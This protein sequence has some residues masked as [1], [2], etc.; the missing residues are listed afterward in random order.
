MGKY[1]STKLVILTIFLACSSVFAKLD[2]DQLNKAIDKEGLNWKAGENWVTRL[3]PEERKNLVGPPINYNRLSK[4]AQDKMIQLPKTAELPEHF[5]WRKNNGNWVTPVK[6]QGSCGSCWS[7]SAVAQTESWWV[8]DND[9]QDTVE[10]FDLSEQYLLAEGSA[11]GCDGG[12]VTAALDVARETGI[13]PEWCLEY[14]MSDTVEIEEADPDWQEYAYQIPGW[15][16]VTSSEA[17][18]KNIKNALLYHPVSASYDVYESFYYYNGGVYEPFTGEHISLENDTLVGGH[19]ILLVG[20]DDRDSSWICKNSWGKY[21]PDSVDFDNDGKLDSGYF[22]I[23]WG[24]C[25]I[26]E[27][28]P[29]IWNDQTQQGNIAFEQNSINTTAKQ[30][31]S[32]QVDFTVTNTGAETVHFAATD[33]G[34]YFHPDTF[35]AYEGASWWCGDPAIMGYDNRVLQYLYIAGLNLT[36][37]TEPV[38]EFK[39][40]WSIEDPAGA[41]EWGYDGWDGW[42]VW[43]STDG[44]NDRQVIEPTSPQYDCQNLWSFGHQTE[45]WNMGDSIPGWAGKSQGWQDIKFDLTD[46]STQNTNLAFV[47]AS[48]RGYSTPD[49][50]SLTGLFIDNIVVYDNQNPEDTLYTNYGNVDVRSLRTGYG[51]TS[52]WL[53]LEN[54]PGTIEAGEDYNLTVKCDAANLTPGNYSGQ[55][56]IE[57]SDASSSVQVLPVNF[58]VT[59]NNENIISNDKPENFTL[60]GNYPNPFNASTNI[61]YYLPEAGNVE[62]MIYNL[63]GQKIYQ[64]EKQY[65]GSGYR[66]MHWNGTDLNG[67]SI[68]TGVYIY[69]VQFENQS[70]QSGKLLLMK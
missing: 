59:E 41:S 17:S 64:A 65:K 36:A 19:A 67:H 13:P 68:G 4:I 43:I 16:Y 2:V 18:V 9:R 7:F 10:A 56:N 63:Q 62:L 33:Y 34:F 23:K 51:A 47:F 1:F 55:L 60:M 35:N 31:E 21:W 27:Y 20:W 14:D 37:L 49:D 11:G 32:V 42:N 50:P 44:I 40:N 25:N 3:S 69:K 54:S 38:L 52:K 53:S 5:D 12:W 24:A 8:I 46:Y 28:M 30:G 70:F 29:F 22:K 6:N 48:D 15:G 26:G 57:L 58:T 45:G 61:K 39:A 66:M